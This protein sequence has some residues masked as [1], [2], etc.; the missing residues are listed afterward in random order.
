M[1]RK[2]PLPRSWNHRTKA[3]ILQVLALS[4]YAFTAMVA[5]AANERSRRTR[6]R[7]EIDR[8]NHELALLREELRIKNARMK[9]VPP[10]RRPHYTPLERMAILE[11]RAARGWSARQTAG[12]LHLTVTTVG[13]WMGRINEE[14][15]NALL[16]LRVP[17]NKFPDLVRYIV[18]RLKLL[19]P[20]LGKVK[21]AQ[22]LCRAGLHLGAT[23]VRRMIKEPPP[24]FPHA[25]A[26]AVGGPVVTAKGPD[27][28]W[29]IDLTAVP[30]TGGFW[31][32]W[33]PFAVF[34]T[35]PFG[36]WVR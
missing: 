4:H 9:R 26:A 19:C 7:A 23:T 27:D 15:P 35:W 22:I 5:R 18:R 31:A 11:L 1:D 10:H 2:I 25:N 33:N 8:L 32:S 20:R 6:F 36:W 30:I 24:V 17:V 16:Q 3:A 12:R 21:I 28:V 34:P 14:G 29:H 13:A